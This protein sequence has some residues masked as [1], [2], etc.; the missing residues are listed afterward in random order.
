MIRKRRKQRLY[1]LFFQVLPVTARLEVL[2]C[3][4]SAFV[5]PS[6]HVRS[7]RWSINGLTTELQRTYNGPTLEGTESSQRISLKPVLSLGG[8]FGNVFHVLHR[9]SSI[10]SRA[11]QPEINACCY[12]IET[13]SRL[14]FALQLTHNSLIIFILGSSEL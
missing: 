12:T 14:Y 9:F 1:P 4:R 10:Q 3:L 2:L 5:M 11:N 13:I 8:W 6:L 7:N